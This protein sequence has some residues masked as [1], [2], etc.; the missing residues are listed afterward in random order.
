[1]QT[2]PPFKVSISSLFSIFFFP[3][4][5]SFSLSCFLSPLPLFLPS[6]V[7]SKKVQVDLESCN[8]AHTQKRRWGLLRTS[9]QVRFSF[10]G[11]KESYKNKKNQKKTKK[12]KKKSG[13]GMRQKNFIPQCFSP[14]YWVFF[15]LLSRKT[16]NGRFSR[17][18]RLKKEFNLISFFPLAL[19]FVFWRWH[20]GCHAAPGSRK[21]QVPNCPFASTGLEILGAR[22]NETGVGN[23]TTLPPT[24]KG[25][26]RGSG[27]TRHRRRRHPL[28][29]VSVVWLGPEQREGAPS[30]RSSA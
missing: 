28:L 14:F 23:K 24:P 8:E 13:V 1:M 16:R 12:K 4:S 6:S 27:A 25:R 21:V 30:P 11:A 29:A 15:T 10:K 19:S 26:C 5:F 3:L 7:I 17:K 2:P 18:K 9:S 20:R 22:G